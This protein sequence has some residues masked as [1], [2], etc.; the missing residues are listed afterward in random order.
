LFQF[1]INS[2]TFDY[3]TSTFAQVFQLKG[4]GQYGM[5]GNIDNVPTNLDL[6]LTILPQ[7]PYDDSSIA[8]FLKKI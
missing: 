6:V 1:Q 4:Y 5:H 2:R 3:T 8:I 7:L